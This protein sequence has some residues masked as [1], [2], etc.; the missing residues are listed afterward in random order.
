MPYL[1]NGPLGDEK[2][3][4]EFCYFH[5]LDR[6][7]AKEAELLPFEIHTVL[8]NTRFGSYEE[9]AKRNFG[10]VILAMKHAD[11]ELK[12]KNAFYEYLLEVQ[13]PN[14]VY[15]FEEEEALALFTILELGNVFSV[16]I[17]K[18]TVPNAPSCN[19][20]VIWIDYDMVVEIMPHEVKYFTDL[21][22]LGDKP[23]MNITIPTTSPTSPIYHSVYLLDYETN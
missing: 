3:K 9:A 13:N 21:M 15:E 10:I 14:D 5:W 7:W 18:S 19:A 8:A 20:D 1:E 23:M 17:G 12:Y 2:Y 6:Q 4:F 11:T 16:Y 22:A